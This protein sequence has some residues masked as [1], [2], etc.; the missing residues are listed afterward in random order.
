MCPAAGPPPAAQA[1]LRALGHTVLIV[2]HDPRV[3]A[4][5]LGGKVN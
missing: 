2:S 5:Y 3:V 1:Q 4:S